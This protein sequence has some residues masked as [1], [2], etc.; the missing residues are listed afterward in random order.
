MK[1]RNTF[2][3]SVQAERV[4]EGSRRTQERVVTCGLLTIQLGCYLMREPFSDEVG[5][6]DPVFIPEQQSSAVK[7]LSPTGYSSVGTTEHK[8]LL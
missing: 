7:C 3:R 5:H 2:H 1:G 6:W 4:A 8:D